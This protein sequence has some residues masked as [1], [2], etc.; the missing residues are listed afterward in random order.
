MFPQEYFHQK[1][2]IEPR[3]KYSRGSGFAEFNLLLITEMNV[4]GEIYS[5]KIFNCSQQEHSLLTM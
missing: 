1:L 3:F 5:Y 4:K 2:G